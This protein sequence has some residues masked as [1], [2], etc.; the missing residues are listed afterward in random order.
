MLKEEP[1]DIGGT[2][3]DIS[4]CITDDMIGRIKGLNAALGSKDDPLYERYAAYRDE[5][6]HAD[7][8]IID[9]NSLNRSSIMNLDLS[10]DTSGVKELAADFFQLIEDTL[11]LAFGDDINCYDEREDDAMEGFSNWGKTDFSILTDGVY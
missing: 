7:L 1:F 11:Q 4:D 3:L 6:D 9:A 10:G 5:I 2:R 8:I